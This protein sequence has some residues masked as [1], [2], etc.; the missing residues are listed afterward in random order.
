MHS[1]LHAVATIPLGRARGQQNRKDVLCQSRHA[2]DQL[3]APSALQCHNYCASIRR[4]TVL[5]Y[6]AT[7]L[8][9]H[10]MQGFSCWNALPSCW[11]MLLRCLVQSSMMIHPC[12]AHVCVNCQQ[13]PVS[14]T[15]VGLRPFPLTGKSGWIPEAAGGHFISITP[16]VR[17]RG[18][19]QCSYRPSVVQSVSDSLWRLAHIHWLPCVHDIVRTVLIA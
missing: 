11:A 5:L 14:P 2:A 1:L 6:T 17:P 10:H 4:A 13:V 9:S 16:L 19:V 18:F 8:S 12:I 15:V 7:M 3:G